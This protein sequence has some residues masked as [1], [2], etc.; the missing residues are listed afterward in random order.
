MRIAFYEKAPLLTRVSMRKAVRAVCAGHRAQSKPPIGDKKTARP[1]EW[2]CSGQSL[3]Y[4]RAVAVTGARGAIGYVC[5]AAD[6]VSLRYYPPHVFD[7][8]RCVSIS[9]RDEGDRQTYFIEPEVLEASEST[10]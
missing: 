5:D 6:V 8:M 4:F 3:A 2:L 7:E 9:S 1:A 10:P